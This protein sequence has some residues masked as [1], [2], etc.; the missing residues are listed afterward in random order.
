M[1]LVRATRPRPKVL[2]GVAPAGPDRL[3]HRHRAGGPR[4]TPPF[5][6]A[7]LL[8]CRLVQRR[9][10]G[11]STVPAQAATAGR[12]SRRPLFVLGGWCGERLPDGAGAAPDRPQERRQGH[13]EHE[14]QADHDH[15]QANHERAR[16]GDQAGQP[17]PHEAP[18]PAAV[19]KVRP[20][21]RAKQAD[22]GEGR[23]EQCETPAAAFAA[24]ALDEQAGCDQDRRQEPAAGAEPW[25]DEVAPQVGQLAAARQEQGDQGHDPDDEDGDPDE[26]ADDLGVD[27]EAPSPPRPPAAARAAGGA[28][29]R[30]PPPCCHA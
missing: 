27:A 7:A 16:V 25:R 30:G 3:A 8:G 1:R 15:R 22:V 19:G 29:R 9:S 12:G 13:V 26:G 4:S 28:A 20:V 21:D 10:A 17:V 24:G 2:A 23:P 6:L 11:R 18:D 14:Q 5:R